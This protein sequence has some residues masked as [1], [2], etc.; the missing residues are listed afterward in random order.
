MARV[1]AGWL[2]LLLSVAASAQE[3]TD[4]KVAELKWAKTLVT[5]FLSAGTKREY[6]QATVL[7]SEELKKALEKS[8]EPGRT[9]VSNR[10]SVYL[11]GAKDW[12]ITSEDIA[13]DQDEAVFRGVSS[14]GQEEAPFTVRVVKEKDSGKWRVNLFKVGEWK[15]KDGA[16]KR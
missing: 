16:R 9:F 11:K 6:D 1:L 2:L 7:L 8:S 5:D 15:K 12:S 14:L 10:F 4:K 13:P 3:K